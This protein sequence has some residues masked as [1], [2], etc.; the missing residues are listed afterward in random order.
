MELE[1]S[2][3]DQFVIVPI[4]IVYLGWC[5]KKCVSTRDTMAFTNANSI[6]ALISKQSNVLI[7]LTDTNGNLKIICSRITDAITVFT[8]TNNFEM[9]FLQIQLANV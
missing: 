3:L 4:E 5:Y 1:S 8:V 6:S 9:S 2:C 7:V